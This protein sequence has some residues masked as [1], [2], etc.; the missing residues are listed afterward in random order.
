[1]NGNS[2]IRSIFWAA[3]IILVTACGRGNGEASRA[4]PE[5]GIRATPGATEETLSRYREKGIEP[6][7]ARFFREWEE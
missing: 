2:A 4:E 6:R 5:A 3:M 1:M 7:K